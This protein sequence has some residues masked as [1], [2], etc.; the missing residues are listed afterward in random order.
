MKKIAAW[1]PLAAL[2]LAL[3]SG[4][5]DPGQEVEEGLKLWFPTDPNQEQ[6]S[7]ALDS[8]PYQGEGQSIPSLLSALLE[9]PPQEAVE[10]TSIIPGGTR[11]PR[12]SAG[13]WRTGWPM[14]SCPPPTP[15]WW[16]LT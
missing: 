14:W 7:A 16:A 13:R 15:S 3:A 8:C 4:C 11:V 2:L 12:C 1:L 5:A 9:G 10:L 6:L